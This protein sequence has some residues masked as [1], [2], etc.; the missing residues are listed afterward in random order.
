MF[1]IL[2]LGPNCALQGLTF[3]LSVTF[4][5]FATNSWLAL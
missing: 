2:L 3:V 1:T 4:L 5:R